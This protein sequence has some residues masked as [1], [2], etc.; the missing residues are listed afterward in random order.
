MSED[1]DQGT[2]TRSADATGVTFYFLFWQGS[3]KGLC[4]TLIVTLKRALVVRNFAFASADKVLPI[5]QI[6]VTKHLLVRFQCLSILSWTL[7]YQFA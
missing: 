1:I 5:F 4:S 6:T 3:L 2:R 7:F